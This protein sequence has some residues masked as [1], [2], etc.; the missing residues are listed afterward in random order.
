L[1]TLFTVHAGEFVVGDY[2]QRTFRNVKVWLPA[3]DTGVDLLIS[4]AANKKA[5]SLQV[6]FSRDFLVTH[7][8]PYFQKRLRVF[9][10]WSLNRQKIATSSAA[11]W[12]LV[13]LGFANQSTDFMIIKPAEL[14]KRLDAIH[15]RRK[16]V[17]CYFWVTEKRQCWE[18]RGLTLK[19]QKSIA[20]GQFK[21]QERDI[22]AYLN[23]WG[24]IEKLDH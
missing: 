1:K 14:L 12:I 7:K 23:D 22:T 20:D 5:V 2:I 13:M 9:G 10:W 6:K 18:T 21:K 15:G 24:P 8:S 11:Y 16:T 4:D 17:H 3:R 19:D